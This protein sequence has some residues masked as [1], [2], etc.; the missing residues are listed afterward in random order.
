MQVRI[1][2]W[3]ADNIRCVLITPFGA[4][5]EPDVN[6]TL[7]IVSALTR[8]WASSTSAV[9]DV[10][11]SARKLIDCRSG[12]AVHETTSTPGP[13]DKLASAFANRG[14]SSANTSPGCM[15]AHTAASVR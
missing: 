7:A 9:G 14:P 8:A 13:S 15:A 12:N 5:V 4:P 2:S 1:C 10:S 11:V 6:R 3:F